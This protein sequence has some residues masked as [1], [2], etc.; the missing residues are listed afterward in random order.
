MRGPCICACLPGL[1]T[2]CLL[3]TLL[4]NINAGIGTVAEQPSL[5]SPIPPEEVFPSEVCNCMSQ[6]PLL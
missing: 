1:T 3:Q 4:K 2:Y 6:W 5:P